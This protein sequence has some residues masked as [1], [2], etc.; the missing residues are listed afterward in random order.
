M[1]KVNEAGI[2]DNLLSWMSWCKVVKQD[3]QKL[4][5]PIDP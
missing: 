1:S 4:Q 3:E 5:S 2:L